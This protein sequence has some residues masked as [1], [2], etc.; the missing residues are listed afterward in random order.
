MF[1]VLLAQEA[2]QIYH[3]GRSVRPENM[4]VFVYFRILHYVYNKILCN[5]WFKL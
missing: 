2:K 4:L 1:W 5:C 3:F